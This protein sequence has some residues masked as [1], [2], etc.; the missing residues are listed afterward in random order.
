[1]KDL[2][3]NFAKVGRMELEIVEVQK[4]EIPLLERIDMVRSTRNYNQHEHVDVYLKLLNDDREAV[5]LRMAI[6][7]ALG[8]YTHSPARQKIIDNCSV[9]GKKRIPSPLK[10]ELVQTINRLK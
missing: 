5:D 2:E 3:K 7:E 6:A 8:W 4:R 10:E 9:L 1:M